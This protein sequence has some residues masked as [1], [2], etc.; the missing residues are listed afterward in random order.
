[1]RPLSA[2]NFT[3]RPRK[4]IAGYKS[5]H[6]ATITL[7][8]DAPSGRIFSTRFCTAV[9]AAGK[10]HRPFLSY[11]KAAISDR[12]LKTLSHTHFFTLPQSLQHHRCSLSSIFDDL[13]GSHLGMAQGIIFPNLPDVLQI[14]ILTH[15]WF[16]HRP[17]HLLPEV[18]RVGRSAD[19]CNPPGL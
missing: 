6:A 10:C 19:P 9:Y 17:H 7:Q 5:G 18:R 14:K 12:L 8:R 15:C 4:S 3:G 16:R 2:R 1:M 11:K 13:P